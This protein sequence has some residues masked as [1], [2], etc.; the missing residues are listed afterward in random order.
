MNRLELLSL[1]HR[2]KELKI[3]IET[4]GVNRARREK[5]SWENR[6]GGAFTKLKLGR[7]FAVCGWR[8][9]VAKSRRKRKRGTTSWKRP[10]RRLILITTDFAVR[11]PVCRA[12]CP[13]EIGTRTRPPGLGSTPRIQITAPL[14]FNRMLIARLS[15][16]FAFL[17]LF[18]SLSPFFILFV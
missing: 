12:N 18:S 4:D 13:V 6:E 8:F 11:S 10:F 3:H 1:N 2:K 5:G 14:S 16:L 7:Q 15:E 17:F 9:A